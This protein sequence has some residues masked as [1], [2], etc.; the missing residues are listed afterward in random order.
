MQNKGP[1]SGTLMMDSSEYP[2]M[3]QNC[4]A[5]VRCSNDARN[6]NLC[7]KQQECNAISWKLHYKGGSSFP[8]VDEKQ[9]VLI[10]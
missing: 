9:V 3:I 10:W 4:L 7:G 2:S 1:Y 8:K 5:L 6:Y